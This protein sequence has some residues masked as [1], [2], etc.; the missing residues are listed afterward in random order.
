MGLGVVTM[1]CPLE[2][3]AANSM[4]QLLGVCCA[5]VFAQLSGFFL[6]TKLVCLGS[7][8][9]CMNMYLWS[10]CFCRIA[11]FSQR[12]KHGSDAYTGPRFSGLNKSNA[13][14]LPRTTQFRVVYN[15]F[16]KLPL[17]LTDARNCHNVCIGTLPQGEMV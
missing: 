1:S 4:L 2:D 6:E 15:C 3:N 5:D 10:L 9:T 14:Y 13:Q 8:M 17:C 11:G 16:E 12:S 7:D